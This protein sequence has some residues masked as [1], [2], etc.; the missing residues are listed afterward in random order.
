M[1]THEYCHAWL[2][3]LSNVTGKFLQIC[4]VELY[5]L[6]AFFIWTRSGTYLKEHSSS[7]DLK[8]RANCK[9]TFRIESVSTMQTPGGEKSWHRFS[10]GHKAVNWRSCAL[11]DRSLETSH[12]VLKCSTNPVYT[13]SLPAVKAQVTWLYS[14]QSEEC[15]LA[16]SS[17][18][19]FPFGPT[20]QCLGPK[21]DH[22]D[23]WHQSWD[24]E[25]SAFKDTNGRGT[26]ESHTF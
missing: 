14:D 7:V 3:V 5:Q 17:D 6:C 24:F 23:I 26:A 19:F 22:W 13:G 16:P 8:Q 4:E 11:A 10:C 20:E 2:Q 12:R 25:S 21:V 9:L 15:R 18:E 1:I